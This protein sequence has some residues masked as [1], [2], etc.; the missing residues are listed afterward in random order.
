MLII[1]KLIWKKKI[2]LPEMMILSRK[3]LKANLIS[4]NCKLCILFFK[5]LKYIHI[6][7][8]KYIYFITLLKVKQDTSILMKIL[9]I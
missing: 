5:K 6:I 1:I 4:M 9:Q 3:L 8:Y 2:L 7:Y